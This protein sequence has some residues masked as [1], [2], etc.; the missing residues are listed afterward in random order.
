MLLHESRRSARTDQNGDVILLEEQ[1]RSLWQ[2]DLIHE[3]IALVETALRSGQ[4]G[5]YTLQ[6]AIA[7]VHA[8]ASTP[9]QTDWPQI[10]AL[11]DRL[12][13]LE[14]SPVIRLNRAVAVAMRDGAEAGLVLIDHI[15]LEEALS[16]YYWLHAARADLYRRLGKTAEAEAAYQKALALTQQEP[17]RRFIQKR[18]A[19]VR[20]K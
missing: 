16:D 3:G 13:A 6:A 20:Q 17:E 2:Q 15:Q 4:F 11:Y 12:M 10:V 8:E 18:L 1:D 5:P 14:P 19:E 7:A 9:Q